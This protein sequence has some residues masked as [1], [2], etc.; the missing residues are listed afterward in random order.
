MPFEEVLAAVKR[1]T[2][3]FESV[4]ILIVV[5]IGSVEVIALRVRL[6]RHLMKRRRKR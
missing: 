1:S 4:A 5:A 6:F 3:V 2:E